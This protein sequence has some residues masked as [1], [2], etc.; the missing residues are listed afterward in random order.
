MIF[1][2]FSNSSPE[3]YPAQLHKITIQNL[4]IEITNVLPK[5][6]QVK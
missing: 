5:F 4:C 6:V 3:F 2:E 1:G